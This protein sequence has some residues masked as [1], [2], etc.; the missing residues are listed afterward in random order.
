MSYLAQ[1]STGSKLQDGQRIVIAGVEKTGKT[2]LGSAAPNALLIPLEQG[3]AAIP[4]PKV[5]QLTA[6][7]GIMDLCEELRSAAI[8]GKLP[9]GTSLV[10]DSATALER[11]I[12]NYTL[13]SSPEWVK[14]KGVG[15]TMAT[16][17][18]AYG[19]AYDVSKQ[20]FERWLR[21]Q[22]ELAFNAGINIIITCHV[23]ASRVVD[24]AH[25]EYDTWDLLLHSPKNNKTYG[26]REYLTQ[27][28]DLIGFMHEPMFVMKAADGAQLNQAMSKNEG[29]VL[30]V[31]R[32]PAWVAGNRYGMSGTV[33]IP[34]PEPGKLAVHS[35][36]ALA[37]A[38]WQATGQRIDLWNR[39][40]V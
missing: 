38:V 12:E 19:K 11:A 1:I 36:N 27:W 16:A 37:D 4:V 33:R 14:S 24:P 40:N 17:H 25:G 5:P 9:R 23:F 6:Y 8:A 3:S 13:R 18:G 31:D 2:T 35:W 26:M 22:D 39:S 28:A 34:P 30:A 20:N 32:T 29:R 21:Y 7:E 10:W 15:V